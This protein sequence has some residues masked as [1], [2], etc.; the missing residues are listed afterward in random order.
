MNSEF[1]SIRHAIFMN[2]IASSAPIRE[3]DLSLDDI[4]AIINDV[5]KDYIS[6]KRNGKGYTDIPGHEKTIS[7]GVNG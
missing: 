2:F 7:V 4:L 1:I 5:G 6:N 3:D